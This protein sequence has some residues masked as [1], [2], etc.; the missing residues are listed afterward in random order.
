MKSYSAA[1]KALLEEIQVDPEQLKMG[2]EVEHEHT[3]DD[4]LAKKIAIDH[5][6]EDPKYYTKLKACKL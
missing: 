5:L 3:D 4:E 6:R 1:Y 2:I